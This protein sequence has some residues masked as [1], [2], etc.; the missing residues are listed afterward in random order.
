M[1]VVLLNSKYCQQNTERLALLQNAVQTHKENTYN[2]RARVH[3][4]RNHVSGTI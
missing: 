4:Y 3:Q 2:V 1:L